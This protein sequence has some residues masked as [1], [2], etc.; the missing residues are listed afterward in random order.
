MLKLNFWKPDSKNKQKVKAYL[1]IFIF[2]WILFILSNCGFDYAEGSFH[3]KLAEHIVTT[4]QLGFDTPQ[5]GIFS[6]APNGRTYASQEIGNTIF[7]LPTAF[8]NVIL[9]RILAPFTTV[10]VI[11]ITKEFIRSFQPGFYSALTVT[12]FFGILRF[13][14]GQAILPSFIATLCLAVSTYFWTYTRESFDGVLCSTLLTTSFLLLL[15][16]RNNKKNQYLILAFICLG[17]SLI[18]RIS[19]ILAIVASLGYL[20][21]ISRLSLISR[22]KNVATALLIIFPFLVWQSWYNHLRTGFFYL[23]PV[24]TDAKYLGNNALD[25]NIFIGLTGLLLSPGKSIFIYAPLLILSVVL[26]RKFF[27]EHKK[28]ALYILVLTIAWFLLH[29]RLRSWYGGGGW[30][31]R[32]LVTILPILFLPFA[33]NLE[34]VLQRTSLKLSAIFLA[35]FGFILSFSSILSH[36]YWRLEFARKDEVAYVWKFSNSQS[37]DM[38][39]S[40]A[41]NLLN[42]FKIATHS[43]GIQNQNLWYLNSGIEAYGSHTVNLWPNS[44]VFIGV[45]WYLVATSVAFLLLMMY[46]SIWNIFNL[47]DTSKMA[48]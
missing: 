44:L 2:F 7:F 6:I 33:T 10:K 37:L 3:Y 24:Q 15:N 23:S 21:L 42:S 31:P 43:P 41:R 48:D 17:F 1:S 47:E 9:E 32:Y 14:F 16:F 36:W 39:K 30:G 46:L 28:E 5:E 40:A 26:F 45:P 18:T 11:S 12:A 8:I 35:G 13:Q 20:V 25:G 34:Y 29:A 38:L 27:K 19:M 22:A 4:G